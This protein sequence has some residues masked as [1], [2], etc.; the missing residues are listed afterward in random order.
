M[1]WIW[2]NGESSTAKDKLDPSL[3]DFL[4][5]EAPTGTKAPSL[6]SP[7]KPARKP[8]EPSK[9][10]QNNTPE[11]SRSGVP[12]ESHFPDGRYAHLWKGYVPQN[13]LEAQGVSEQ[14]KLKDIVEAYNDRK[15]TL[16][17]A[18]LE[19][20]AFEYLEQ[21]NCFKSPGL[22]QTATLC[23]AESQ[24]FNRCYD[25][26]VKFLK[27]LG[28]LST[29]G[30]PAQDERV[31]MHADKLYQQMMEQ[32]R[33]VAQAKEEGTP[34]PKFE[35]VLSQQNIARAISNAPVK[36]RLADEVR[37]EQDA[38]QAHENDI[39]SLIKPE[40][41]A[42]Y[43]KKIGELPVEDQE[44]ERKAFLGELRS[45]QGLTK[46]VEEAFVEERLNRM[47][48]RDAGQATL[49]DTIKRWWGWG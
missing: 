26:Q 21:Y 38:E 49:G 36:N 19:N 34:I 20:C 4:E 18:A 10:E 15:A 35:S 41:R 13:A 40:S 45:K 8:D 9:P 12:S 3:R 47:R 28:Y 43:E 22:W 44:F 46:K 31:Q 32:Q 29:A 2:G 7:P 37:A 11:S 16:G 39:W 42:E 14:E 17:Q 30:G 33:L 6:P 24:K 5:K 27:A 1:G 23:H 48:R 25:L